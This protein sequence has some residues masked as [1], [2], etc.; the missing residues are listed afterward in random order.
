M[1]GGL[2]FV[3]PGV[4]L[5]DG[6]VECERKADRLRGV[7]EA[8]GPVEQLVYLPGSCC[9]PSIGRGSS[10]LSWGGGSVVEAVE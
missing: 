1:S 10:K 3:E 6:L 8:G 7:V 9:E 5:G 4:H 2:E